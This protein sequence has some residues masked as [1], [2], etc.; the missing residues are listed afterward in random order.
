MS[1]ARIKCWNCGRWVRAEHTRE[2]EFQIAR[3]GQ[4]MSP[5]TITEAICVSCFKSLKNT[6]ESMQTK[7]LELEEEENI[8]AQTKTDRP[9]KG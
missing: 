6:D 2:Q 9:H 5:V 8:Y 1:D 7:L 4:G 3:G